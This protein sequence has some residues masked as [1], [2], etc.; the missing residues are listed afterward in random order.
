M[1]TGVQTLTSPYAC[2]FCT[3]VHLYPNVV[4]GTNAH[5]MHRRKSIYTNILCINICT[6]ICRNAQKK[7]ERLHETL[8]IR[9]FHNNV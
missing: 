2:I 3:Q 8:P 6:Y 5:F 4:I 7:R 9:R 1:H